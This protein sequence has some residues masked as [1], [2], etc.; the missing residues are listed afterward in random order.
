M[1][2]ARAG[3]GGCGAGGFA[4]KRGAVGGEFARPPV[5]VSPTLG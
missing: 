4:W 3:S 1:Y 2:F 5:A